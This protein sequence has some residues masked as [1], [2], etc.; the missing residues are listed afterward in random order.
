MF[1]QGFFLKNFKNVPCLTWRWICCYPGFRRCT[2]HF[3]LEV[4]IAPLMTSDVYSGIGEFNQSPRSGAGACQL[5][6]L[7]QSVD[8]YQGLVMPELL[9]SLSVF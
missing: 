8:V 9:L 5:L 2:L 7:A 4:V 1:A 3:C 6:A